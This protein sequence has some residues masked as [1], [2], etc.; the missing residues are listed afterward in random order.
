M[1]DL[2]ESVNKIIDP[3]SNYYELKMPI[4]QVNETMLINNNEKRSMRLLAIIVTT[5][6]PIPTPTPPTPPPKKKKKE[7]K[8]ERRQKA[9]DTATTDRDCKQEV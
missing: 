8:K 1:T 4:S 2:H 7:R 9:Y 5:T 6:T 3:L